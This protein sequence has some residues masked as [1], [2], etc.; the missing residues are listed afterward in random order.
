MAGQGVDKLTEAMELDSWDVE[1][2]DG[3]FLVH[4]RREKVWDGS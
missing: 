2:I 3:D 1:Q 4:A